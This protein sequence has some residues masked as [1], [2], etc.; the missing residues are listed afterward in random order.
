[1]QTPSSLIETRRMIT[2]F[3][4]TISISTVAELG[5]AD[6]LADG[7]KTAAALAAL[8]DS[9]GGFLERVLRYL[10]SEGVFEERDGG[11]FGLTERSNWLRSDVPGSLRPRAIFAGSALNWS[12]WGRLVDSI[13]NGVPGIQLAFGESLFEHLRSHPD[14]AAT[15][16]SFMAQQTAASIEALLG[17]YDFAGVSQIVDVG[18]GHGAL[19]VG[20]LKAYPEMRA[21]LFDL[22][23]VI[24]SARTFLDRAGVINRCELISGD[25]FEKVPAGG[26]LY[27]LKFILHD[28]P[29]ADC[30]R[31]VENCRQAM[32][33]HGRLLIV[34]HVMTQE[35][36]PHFAKFMDLNML[37]LTAGG[38]ERTEHEFSEI[39]SAA[40]L[41]L[42]RM[43]PT[44]IGIF[45]LECGLGA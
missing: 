17:S 44:P 14:A 7:P 21:I 42:I 24:P 28:W 32:T 45:A 31:I 41:K 12:A 16:N 10:A 40:G 11:L 9:D 18:G 35:K 23:E 34:E 26:D 6:H 4:L 2:G 39:L 22:E 3:S 8:T 15:F 13:R 37:V 27:V 5:I 38:R 36:G 20:V 1:M 19:L 30:K 33:P 43:S 29:D 25:F